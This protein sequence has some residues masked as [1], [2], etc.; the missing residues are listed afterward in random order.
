MSRRNRTLRRALVLFLL[1]APLT[2][3]AASAPGAEPKF[4][5]TIVSACDGTIGCP[6]K[7]NLKSPVH[8]LQFH[9]FLNVPT[10]L[11][12]S[13]DKFKIT[14]RNANGE[15]LSEKLTEGLIRREGRSFEY[16]NENARL[17]GGIS[18]LSLRRLRAH[19]WHIAVI[20][21]G[22]M[23][24]ATL[25]PMTLYMVIGNDT[26]LSKNVWSKREFGWLLHLPATVPPPSP[27]PIGPTPTPRP[28]GTP[29]V[30]PTQSGATPTPIPTRTPGPTST[31]IP[32]PTPSPTPSDPYGSVFEAFVAPPRSLLD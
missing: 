26:F 19:L 24:G 14:L 7:I 31:P 32:T 9:A 21:H 15:L 17:G 29:A 30:T 22:D 23:A 3:V 1:I 12:P 8:T 20:A 11:H 6:N 16:R 2:L 4:Q 5:G 18:R 28:S 27:T 25:A 10:P 13:D